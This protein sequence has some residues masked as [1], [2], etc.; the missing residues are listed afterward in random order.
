MK[1]ITVGMT[2][3]TMMT[4][5][6]GTRKLSGWFAERPPRRAGRRWASRPAGWSGAVC[7]GF[8]NVVGTL[9]TSGQIGLS[10]TRHTLSLGQL[11]ELRLGRRRHLL[12]CLLA[13]QHVS[14]VEVQV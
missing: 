9:L 11:G 10:E 14:Q 2:K 13:V 6:A 1:F 8:D 4:A 12:R 5:K 7:G 3:K